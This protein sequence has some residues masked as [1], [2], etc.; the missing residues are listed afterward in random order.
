M[1]IHSIRM[2]PLTDCFLVKGDQAVLL[3][4]AG[5]PRHEKRFHRRLEEL[6][7][8]PTDIKLIVVTH[9]HADHVGSLRALKRRTK[10]RVA[11]HRR[12]GPLIRHGVITVPPA[13]TAWGRFLS[14][15]FRFLSFLGRFEPVEPEILIDRE[16]S[17][18]EFGIQG[19]VI[20]T[21]GHTAGSVS[22]VLRG[23]EAFVGDLAVNAFPLNMGL[24]IPAVA[25]NIQEIYASWEKIL[26]AGATMIYPAH[27][28]PFPADR[29]RD[30]LVR[31]S[32]QEDRKSN[33]P[34]RER[35]DNDF[36]HCP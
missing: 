6:G 19:R 18:R 14:V 32:Y 34:R 31:I 22:V 13:V 24:G 30:K 20:P 4:D 7:F 17:L 21:P 16:I 12:E 23:G 3:V 11:I 2:G 5:F 8:Q 15:L 9:G 35:K 25:E 1:E 29:L 36:K 28:K 26:R 10:A 27:G 33:N